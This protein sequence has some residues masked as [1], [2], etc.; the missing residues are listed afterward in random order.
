MT[1]CHNCGVK[2]AL[3]I[4]KFCP[5]CGI[6]LQ[7]KASGAGSTSID[8]TQGG[9][10][11]AGITGSGNITGREIG[12]TVQ[13][14]VIYLQISGSLSMEVL[15]SLQ[16]MM[17]VPIRV[18]ETHNVSDAGAV[19][20]KAIE[21]GSAH[22]QIK[23]ILSEVNSIEKNTG[24]QI[25][26]INAGDLH[27]SKNELTLKEII[28]KGNEHYYKKEFNEAIMWYDK[29]L[30][31]ENNNFDL[32]Y[33]KG[34]ALVSLG[35][36]EDAVKCY[37]KAIEIDPGRAFEYKREGKGWSLIKLGKQDEAIKY[38][39]K[40]LE[41]NPKD[42][43]ALW[44]KALFLSD[45]HRYEEAIECYDEISKLNPNSSNVWYNLGTVFNRLAKY[46]EA[47]KM[48]DKAIELDP[49]SSW[50]WE[51]KGLALEN[52]GKY[53][54]AIKCYDKAIELDPN[55]AYAWN[56]KGAYLS[57]AGK[58]EEAV[59]CFDKAIYL[60]S[61]ITELDPYYEKAYQNKAKAL[62]RLRMR[63]DKK[64]KWYTSDGQPI[65]K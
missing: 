63:G 62:D 4:E 48:F 16:K 43:T 45:A 47:I 9:V 54:E 25:Q 51:N 65:N 35:K 22:Q 23:N 15:D 31:I 33:N 41:T 44:N 42:L 21:S 30:G 3:G 60:Y 26:A 55:N 13:G 1:F 18:E 29:A 61:K 11:G 12:Y 10:F 19:K 59:Q 17:A 39:E 24:T 2:L 57:D 64:I 20:T 34:Y 38:H 28:L 7:G 58:Y 32:W 27:I 49:N 36:Y 50:T 5:N 14:N 8:N 56:D 53:N 40:A 52:L 6:K 46:E 37:D